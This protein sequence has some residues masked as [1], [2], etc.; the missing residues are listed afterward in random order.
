MTTAMQ[1]ASTDPESMSLEE[2]SR[3]L[4]AYKP[5]T[6]AAVVTVEDW[7]TRRRALWTRLDALLGVKKPIARAAG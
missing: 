5:T 2:I 4:A 3:E 1:A 6:Q 7:L